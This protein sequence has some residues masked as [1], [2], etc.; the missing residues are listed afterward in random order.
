MLYVCL[1]GVE[2]FY[3]ATDHELMVANKKAVF[4][5]PARRNVSNEAKDLVSSVGVGGG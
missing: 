5:F 1:Y 2:P 4:D 3:A